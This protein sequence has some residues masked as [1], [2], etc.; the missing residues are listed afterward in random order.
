MTAQNR[1]GI[2]RT[3]VGFTARSTVLHVVTYFVIGAVSYWFVARR[4]WTGSEALP[5][6][7]NPEGEFV[8]RWFLP[9]QVVRGVLHGVALFPLRAALLNMPRFGGLA[10]ASLLLLIGSIAGISGVIEDWVY[11]TTF[12]LRLFMAHLPE[13]VLQ[14]LVYGYLL[15]AWERRVEHRWAEVVTEQV[16]GGLGADTSRTKR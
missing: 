12:H 10:V 14:T 4:F 13:I 1:R 11:S 3:L 9:A 8:Q 6:L 5:W 16:D 15:L 7:R 2:F